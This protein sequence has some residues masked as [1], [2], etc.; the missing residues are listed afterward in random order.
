MTAKKVTAAHVNMMA[1]TIIA[2][3]PVDGLR[4]VV[5]GILTSNPDI[6]SIF[7]EQTRE[8]LCETA[9]RFSNAVLIE[10]M[11]DCSFKIAPLFD[12]IQQRIRCAIGCGMCY[13]TLPLLQAIVDQAGPITLD[14]DQSYPDQDLLLNRIASVDADIVQAMTAVQKTLFVPE[15]TRYL[16][17]EERSPLENLVQSLTSCRNTWENKKQTFVFQRGLDAAIDILNP[18]SH[19]GPTVALPPFPSAEPPHLLSET[20]ELTDSIRLPRIFNGLWQLSSPSWGAASRPKMMDQFSKYVGSGLVAFDMADHYGDA[21]IV[22]GRYRSSSSY[23]ESMFAATKYCVFHPMNVTR[24]A[25]RANVSERCQRLRAR[26]LDLLQFHWQFYDDPHYIDALQYLQ[27]DD[28]VRNLGLCNFDT[29]HMRRVVDSG[30]KVVSNQVQFSLIDS[31]PTVRMAEFC[32]KHNIKLLTYGTL[33]GGLIA[34]KWIGQEPPQ[35][36]GEKMTPSLRKYYSMIQSWGGWGLFQELLRT[37]QSIARKHGVS[38]SN[39]ATRWVLDFPCVGA[40][41]VG[42]R[43]GVSEQLQGNLDSLGWS[44]DHED[45]RLIEEILGRS[46]RAEMFECMGDCGGEYRI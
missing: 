44:L 24:D 41:I 4:T 29:E 28:R 22:F 35:L 46:R 16:T 30:I 27:E 18:T 14:S 1:D 40:V 37:L 25:V 21:E 9:S 43:M 2:S 13:Q 17:V 23:S 6:V 31:R 20:F 10:K 11:P 38:V 8:Y 45:R 42:A 26:E 39:V 33:C 19:D 34:E 5:R 12:E 36:Y 15:G 7:E 3:L 32:E